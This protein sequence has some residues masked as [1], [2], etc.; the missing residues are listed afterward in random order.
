MK[1]LEMNEDVKRAW[2]NTPIETRIKTDDGVEETLKGDK[3]VY[4][5]AK[6]SATRF[7]LQGRR[8]A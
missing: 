5:L 7:V 1:T 4:V 6:E 8:L 3:H 2:A